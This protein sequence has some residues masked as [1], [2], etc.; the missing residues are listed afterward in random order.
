M[1]SRAVIINNNYIFLPINTR[2]GE[3]NL[4]SNALLSIKLFILVHIRLMK[5]IGGDGITNGP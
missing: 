5:M 1:W 3:K 4:D 2:S